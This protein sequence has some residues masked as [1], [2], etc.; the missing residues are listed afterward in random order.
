MSYLFYIIARLPQ[1]R[2]EVTSSFRLRSVKPHSLPEHEQTQG[3]VLSE[4]EVQEI[5]LVPL[6]SI[7]FLISK[8]Q[9]SRANKG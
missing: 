5:I 3:K 7:S 1:R 6:L 8:F 2:P 4:L 9:G